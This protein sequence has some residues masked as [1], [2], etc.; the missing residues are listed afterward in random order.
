MNEGKKLTRNEASFMNEKNV[1]R[2]LE[3]CFMTW[4]K[5]VP[6]AVYYYK[7]KIIHKILLNP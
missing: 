4:K 3:N 2:E 7:I 1:T 5:C 6:Y